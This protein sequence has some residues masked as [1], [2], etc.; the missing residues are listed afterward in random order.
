MYYE[1]L[2]DS[3]C[4]WS[5]PYTDTSNFQIDKCKEHGHP[6]LYFGFMRKD[7]VNTQSWIG[8]FQKPYMDSFMLLIGS[9]P[10]YLT[11][12]HHT[13]K[14][15]RRGDSVY[16]WIDGSRIDSI[17]TTLFSGTDSSLNQFYMSLLMTDTSYTYLDNYS[18]TVISSDSIADRADINKIKLI[19][20]SDTMITISKKKVYLDSSKSKIG[21]AEYS[22]T[23]LFAYQNPWYNVYNNADTLSDS[24]IIWNYYNKNISNLTIPD[25]VTILNLYGCKWDAITITASSSDTINDTLRQ[26]LIL[27][28]YGDPTSRDSLFKINTSN[29]KLTITGNREF[30]INNYVGCLAVVNTRGAILND[31]RFY[32]KKQTNKT[33]YALQ[34]SGSGICERKIE[35]NNCYIESDSTVLGYTGALNFNGLHNAQV[36]VKNTTI[37]AHGV[38]ASEG[39]ALMVRICTDT[40]N[41]YDCTFITDFDCLNGII[42]GGF[43]N[44]LI[45]VY[46]SRLIARNNQLGQLA[47]MCDWGLDVRLY[48]SYIETQTGGFWSYRTEGDTA[49]SHIELHDCYV[50]TRHYAIRPSYGVIKAYNTTFYSTDTS[51]E[52]DTGHIWI[53]PAGDNSHLGNNFNDTLIVDGCTF[54]GH[55]IKPILFS[56]AVNDDLAHDSLLARVYINIKNTK[57]IS[58]RDTLI[59][60]SDYTRDS[61]NIDLE[62]IEYNTTEM[63]DATYDSLDIIKDTT[64]MTNDLKL[65]LGIFNDIITSKGTFNTA[66][67]KTLSNAQGEPLFVNLYYGNY[68]SLLFVIKGVWMDT[69]A[70]IDSFNNITIYNNL[71]VQDTLKGHY[72]DIDTL[73]SDSINTRTAV[74][75]DTLIIGDNKIYDSG[76]STTF[77]G[78]VV[79]PNF[80]TSITGEIYCSNYKNIY[81]TP[82]I[83]NSGYAFDDSLIVLLKGAHSDTVVDVDSLNNVRIWNN[84]TVDDTLKGHYA[85]IDTLKADSI[86]TEELV[87]NDT[88]RIMYLKW[89][90]SKDKTIYCQSLFDLATGR[91]STNADSTIIGTDSLDKWNQGATFYDTLRNE[92]VVYDGFEWKAYA[93]AYVDGLDTISIGSSG[94]RTVKIWTA[95][96]CGGAIIVGDSVIVVKSKGI[97]NVD[98]KLGCKSKTTTHGHQYGISINSAIPA[99]KTRTIEKASDTDFHSISL[100][101]KLDLSRNDT[102][103]LQVMDTLSIGICDVYVKYGNMRVEKR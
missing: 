10:H 39:S 18:A 79:A 91:L 103:R 9:T 14:V 15:E 72:A 4:I 35:I 70:D 87:V 48:D 75:T 78:G 11:E 82:F 51:I 71:E 28:F 27:N 95:G 13:L 59:Y 45:N 98:V 100:G 6:K 26:P 89:A 54:I 20:Q 88:A 29:R 68:D 12:V 60:T 19:Y 74:V 40:F 96:L 3:V 52:N 33:T 58:D 62:N 92:V 31:S 44:A 55:G 63:Y 41:F 93:E 49:C 64:N 17:E 77:S 37:Y 25:T 90:E 7:S 43:G 32:N 57:F 24:T 69:V 81:G 30:V 85:D 34:I 21:Y 86:Y 80:S 84:L 2:G 50:K 83:I 23:T 22:D 16:F 42:D 56:K 102:I 94:W 66:Y 36:D 67:I 5:P 73:K 99:L 47:V 61:F 101:C 1:I 8:L 53:T 97:Y 46:N 65:G 76:I 38:D